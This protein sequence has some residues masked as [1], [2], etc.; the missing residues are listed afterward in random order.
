M[1]Y[2]ETGRV[3]VDCCHLVKCKKK[4]LALVTAVMNRKVPH[5]TGSFFTY[6]GTF[7]SQVEL[8]SIELVTNCTPAG[9]S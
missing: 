3:G 6:W 2:K 9:I 1:D 4:R 5:K 8:F 7:A